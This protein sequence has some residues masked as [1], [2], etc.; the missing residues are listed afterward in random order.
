M[1]CERN[2]NLTFLFKLNYIKFHIINTIQIFMEKLNLATT[3]TLEGVINLTQRQLESTKNAL[4][5]YKH[6]KSELYNKLVHFFDILDSHG[7]SLE[8]SQKYLRNF[9]H[10]LSS[11][12]VYASIQTN[13]NPEVM[14]NPP[15]RMG[16]Y[17]LQLER[18]LL[19]GKSLDSVVSDFEYMPLRFII[20]SK[21]V[22]NDLTEMAN[23]SQV[24]SELQQIREEFDGNEAV[25]Q[26]YS[27]DDFNDPEWYDFSLQGLSRAYGDNE[28]DYE[29]VET[30]KTKKATIAVLLEM[31]D[32]NKRQLREWLAYPNNQLENMSPINVLDNPA[33]FQ[34]V[35]DALG[36]QQH[37]IPS[38]TINSE[39]DLNPFTEA[40]KR[41][42]EVVEKLLNQPMWN[43]DRVVSHFNLPNR[44]P[45]LS[46]L[47]EQNRVLGIYV[48]DNDRL[49]DGYYYPAWQFTEN[50]V[51]KGFS[52]CLRNLDTYSAIE[53]L[54]W[55]E[56]P[57][58]RLKGDI[59]PKLALIEA[60]KLPEPEIFKV[61]EEIV[62]SA[63]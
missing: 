32:G 40:N 36:R 6:R 17:L 35:I 30:P 55:L 49:D 24:R 56:S 16:D 8:K 62:L 38:G 23:D 41:G 45:S 10:F 18:R 19:S 61:I 9:E 1:A 29:I 20:D 43:D 42:K 52:V 53:K 59:S 58:T 4:A 44:I 63:L 28:P 50:T 11:D 33:R 25:I 51:L 34:D 48:S 13:I 47:R 37:N 3:L 22:E 60:N 54:A 2:Y 21:T 5:E 15:I 31:F 27:A 57:N 39:K 46:N 14:D 12:N 7:L 26:D